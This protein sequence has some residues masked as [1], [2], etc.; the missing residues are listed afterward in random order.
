MAN[1]TEWSIVYYANV[2]GS[3]P[4]LE[5]L[6][7]LDAKTQVRFGWAIEQLRIRNVRAG[8]PL[9]RHIEGKIWELRRNSGTDTFRV[10]YFFFT[11]RK[12]VLLHGFQKKTQRTPRH[13]METAMRRMN[14][15]LARAEGE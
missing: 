10:F 8:E 14:D 9:V 6:Q 5:F 2:D 15:F 13:E 11:G 7:G 1:G 12:I 3:S 4:V